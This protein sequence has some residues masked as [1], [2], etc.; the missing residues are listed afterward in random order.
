MVL[1]EMKR[2]HEVDV[3]FGP[4]WIYGD[5][6]IQNQRTMYGE[7]SYSLR[8]ET[9]RTLSLNIKDLRFMSELVLDLQDIQFTYPSQK[10][11]TLQIPEF[12]IRQSEKFF[13]LVPVERENPLC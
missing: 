13:F 3:Q 5:F 2:G 1:V 8:G 7:V 9:H 12:Q 6:Q 11:P 10:H 4:I